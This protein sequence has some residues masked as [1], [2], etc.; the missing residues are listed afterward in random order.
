MKLKEK[1]ICSILVVLFGLLTGF[2]WT[3]EVKNLRFLMIRK[4]VLILDLLALIALK[5]RMAGSVIKY[6]EF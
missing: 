1:I 5:L 2:A 3:S 6:L 4:A